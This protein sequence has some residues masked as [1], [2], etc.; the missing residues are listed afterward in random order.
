MRDG[1]PINFG[2]VRFFRK[3]PKLRRDLGLGKL[4]FT[5]TCFDRNK[6]CSCGK[7]ELYKCS[8]NML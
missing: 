1:I 3:Q 5:I 7:Q 4:V 2:V 8:L 6:R